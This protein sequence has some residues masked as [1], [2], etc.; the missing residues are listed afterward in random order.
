[1]NESEYKRE[2]KIFTDRMRFCDIHK[3]IH[4]GSCL[5]MGSVAF[6]LERYRREIHRDNKKIDKPAT[7]GLPE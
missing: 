6:R 1:M 2:L 3:E 4:P 7:D 5:Y